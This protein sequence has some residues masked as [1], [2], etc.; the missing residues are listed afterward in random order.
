[1]SSA[2]GNL[3]DDLRS[4]VRDI[5]SDAVQWQLPQERWPAV[6]DLIAQLREALRT[7]D[8]KRVEELLTELELAAPLRIKPIGGPQTE[9]A[10]ERLKHVANDLIHDLGDGLDTDA[11]EDDG[12]TGR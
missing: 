11:N 3:S 12:A 7:G 8:A 2:P 6:E 5:V 9:S 1:M 4:D 10:P